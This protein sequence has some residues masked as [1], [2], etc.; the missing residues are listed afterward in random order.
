MILLISELF[1]ANV[2]AVCEILN[3]RR[4]PWFRWNGEDFPLD[5]HISVEYQS[6]SEFSGTIKTSKKEV[7]FQSIRAVW[8]RRQGRYTLPKNL[9][10]VEEDFIYRECHHA[11]LGAYSFLDH[12]SWLNHYRADEAARNKIAQLRVAKSVGLEI[13]PTIITQNPKDAFRFYKSQKHKVI[14]KSINPASFIRIAE[15][16]LKP[17][18]IFTSLLPDTLKEDNFSNVAL[19]P[20]LF[21]GYI[22]KAYELRVTIVGNRIFSALIDSQKSDQTKIDWR[23]YDDSNTPPYCPYLLPVEIE[24]KLLSMMRLLGLEF[25]AIDLIRSVNDKYVFLEI[26]P[27]GQWGWVEDFTGQK[28]TDAVAEWLIHRGNVA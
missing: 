19:T 26:N 17:E 13:P 14:C 12:A 4:V 18:M 2:N 27:G 8:N 1:E 10:R 21:Q 7:T 22:E 20:T 16:E 23:R 9:T 24:H 5:T 15:G 11:R 3:H 28:I 6:G 25:G